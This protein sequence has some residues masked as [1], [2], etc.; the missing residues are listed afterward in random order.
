MT[1]QPT[2]DEKQVGGFFSVDL[3]AFVCAAAGGLNAAVAHLVMARGTGRDNR[4]TQWSAHSIEQRTGVS[5]RN[6]VK[7]V[8]DLV[9][10]GVW[11]KIRDGQHP[12]YEAVPANQIPGGPFTAEEQAVL[13][14]IPESKAIPYEAN[15]TAN[16]LAARGIIRKHQ[17][18]RR[19]QYELDEAAITALT[20]PSAVWLPNALIDGAAQEVPP[21]ELIRQTRSLPALRL[22]IELYAA[23][24]LPDHGGAPREL[25]R[26]QFERVKVGERGPFTVWGFQP[27]RVTASSDLARPFL[28]GRLTKRADATQLDAGWDESF[29]PAVDT[30]LDVGLVEAVGMLLEGGDGEAEIIHPFGISGGEAPEREL[31]VAADAAAQLMLTPGQTDW[32]REQGLYLVPVSRH[33]ANATLISV[34]RLKYRPH[35]AA[36]AAWYATMQ[37]TTTDYLKRYRALGEGRGAGISAA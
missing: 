26:Q 18:G 2:A 22:L 35:T 14:A 15:A 3:A 33:I 11:K 16:A 28:T 7:A 29:W 23:Q 9:Q 36:T 32:A 13:A 34:F 20:Q 27:D 12:I 31:A 10:R 25:L 4:T 21:V 5:R 6:A 30:L 17:A 37:Q 19:D 24:F 1:A 8:N